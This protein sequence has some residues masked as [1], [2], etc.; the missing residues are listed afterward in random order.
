MGFAQFFGGYRIENRFAE[1]FQQ[2][3]E[4]REIRVGCHVFPHTQRRHFHFVQHMDVAVQVHNI[5]FNNFGSEHMDIAVLPLSTR[6]QAVEILVVHVFLLK[7][8]LGKMHHS[9]VARGFEIHA[10]L[11]EAGKL[12]IVRKVGPEGDGIVQYHSG[13]APQAV[14]RFRSLRTSQHGGYV[15]ILQCIKAEKVLN[16]FSR[17]IRRT[18]KAVGIVG[19]ESLKGRIGGHKKAAAAGTLEHLNIRAVHT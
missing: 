14:A 7:I 11:F 3:A 10:A 5:A 1:T 2:T 15:S 8:G 16:E 19:K 18:V 12:R 4:F 17:H 9:P 13:G 6:I